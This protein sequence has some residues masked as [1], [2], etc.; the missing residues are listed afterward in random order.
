MH[1]TDLRWI[2]SYKNAINPWVL[3]HV[4]TDFF[5]FLRKIAQKVHTTCRFGLLKCTS[6]WIKYDSLKKTQV[7]HSYRY[8]LFRCFIEAP[9]MKMSL[10]VI[11]F[12]EIKCYLSE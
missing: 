3:E 7:F 12:H 1:V 8:L 10:R 4:M 9:Y 11:F 2:Q 5:F 6:K